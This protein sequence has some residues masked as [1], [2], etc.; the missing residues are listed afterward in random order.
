MSRY[1]ATA[2]SGS[3]KLVATHDSTQKAAYGI[4]AAWIFGGAAYFYIHFTQVFYEANRG[5]FEL[6][7]Q[8]FTAFLTPG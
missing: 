5:G 6:L 2:S 7:W 3:R 8:R 4:A 1:S